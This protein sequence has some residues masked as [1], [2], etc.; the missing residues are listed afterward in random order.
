MSTSTGVS[1]S[2][3]LVAAIEQRTRQIVGSLGDLGDRALRAPSWLDGWSRLTIACHLRYG[4]EA[5]ALMTRHALR[6]APTSYYPDGREQQ[7]PSTLVPR[8]GE[9]GAAVVASLAMCSDA[10][11]RVWSALTVDDWRLEGSE[12]GDTFDRRSLSLADLAL[13]RL[14]ECEVHGSDLG[15]G[16]DD[17]SPLFVSLALP[18][19]VALLRTRR[20]DH[21]GIPATTTG[22]WLLIATDG[23]THLVSVAH[24]KVQSQQYTPNTTPATAAIEATSRDLLALLLGRPPLGRLSFTGDATFGHS[25]THLFPGP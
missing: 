19:R 6:G 10:L 14:T 7:R 12:L 22:S 13:L 11:V 15:L 8:A 2:R 23:P 9:S 17:W 4:A 20:P 16:L 21:P 25:F 18:F 5:L 24:G 3:A 1:S